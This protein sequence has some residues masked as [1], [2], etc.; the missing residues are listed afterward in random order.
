V[1]GGLH[2]Q[3]AQVPLVIDL[4]GTL[5]GS[6]LLLGSAAGRRQHAGLDHRVAAPTVDTHPAASMRKTS[7]LS[8]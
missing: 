7:R 3:T 6:D 4:D 5:L 8:S 2:T 1:S